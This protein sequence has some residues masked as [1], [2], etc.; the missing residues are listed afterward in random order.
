MHTAEPRSSRSPSRV[1]GPAG[2]LLLQV[3]EKVLMTTI[4]AMKDALFASVILQQGTD[5]SQ[6]QVRI[7]SWQTPV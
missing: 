3:P 6:E 1:P 2:A 4:N 5:L 7:C